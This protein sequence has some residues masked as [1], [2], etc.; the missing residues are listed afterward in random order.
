MAKTKKVVVETPSIEETPKIEVAIEE[1]T[2]KKN[3]RQL[4]EAYKLQNP[5]KYE[6][7]KASFEKKLNEIK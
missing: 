7:R 6:L 4:F 3:L 5:V 2:A 1:S